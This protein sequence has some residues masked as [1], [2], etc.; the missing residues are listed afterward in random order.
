MDLMVA[1]LMQTMI[2]FKF[3]VIVS[4]NGNLYKLLHS[5]VVAVAGRNPTM[6][7]V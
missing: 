3:N 1:N 6:P 2:Y 5:K 4:L 7:I